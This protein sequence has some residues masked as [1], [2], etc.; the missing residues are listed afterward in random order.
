MIVKTY[1]I[2]IKQAWINKKLLIRLTRIKS[3]YQE[4]MSGHASFLRK[5]IWKMKV[6]LRLRFSCGSYIA[7]LFLPEI[8]WQGIIDVVVK[9]LLP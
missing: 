1:G 8:I 3:L 6:P 2:D 9:V 5:Y 4:F 7:K